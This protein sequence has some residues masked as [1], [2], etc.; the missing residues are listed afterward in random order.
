MARPQS[1]VQ[2]EIAFWLIQASS[3]AVLAMTW[4]QRMAE[5]E[6]AAGA[7]APGGAVQAFAV[8]VTACGYAI[9]LLLWYF[10]TR[11]GSGIARWIYTILFALDAAGLLLALA[12]G[13]FPT[14]LMAVSTTAL[15]LLDAFA[16]WLLFRP[17][18]AAWFRRGA[19]AA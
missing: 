19:P 5:A 12:M 17:D 6:A 13:V 1:I 7:F 4:R 14:G 3:F 16:V 15:A 9:H 8:A 18:A 10:I 11:A 2:F